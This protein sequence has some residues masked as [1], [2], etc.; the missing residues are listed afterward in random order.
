[1]TKTT[2]KKTTNTSFIFQRFRSNGLNKY[3]WTLSGLSSTAERGSLSS[4][5]ERQTSSWGRTRVG[6]VKRC[7]WLHPDQCVSSTFWPGIW[8]LGL[9]WATGCHLLL[10]AC[11]KQRCLHKD[12]VSVLHQNLPNWFFLT[13]H[14]SS[15]FHFIQIF[16]LLPSGSCRL[17]TGTLWLSHSTPTAAQIR[18]FMLCSSKTKHRHIRREQKPK[19]AFLSLLKNPCRAGSRWR[20]CHP[21]EHHINNTFR[22]DQRRIQG[23]KLTYFLLFAAIFGGYFESWLR[24]SSGMESV[25]R[26]RAVPSCLLT[27]S[28]ATLFRHVLIKKAGWNGATREPE[29]ASCWCSVSTET[30]GQLQTKWQ[31]RRAPA[32]PG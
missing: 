13:T 9:Y 18:R 28:P 23:G 26:C 11:G 20:T 22:N 8:S 6:A 7:G 10:W 31:L 12:K 17:L 5:A 16:G 2:T 3:W 4:T 14:L 32:S 24:V 1:M 30:V 21:P 25:S 27:P 29:T 19:C 15:A